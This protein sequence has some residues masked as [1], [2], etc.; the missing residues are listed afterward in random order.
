[1]TKQQIVNHALEMVLGITGDHSAPHAESLAVIMGEAVDEAVKETTG[2]ISK[3]VTDA[4]SCG[5]QQQ[6]LMVLK[7]FP[8]GYPFTVEPD[9]HEKILKA[10]M[11]IEP[12]LSATVLAQ[13]NHPDFCPRC[14]ALE[15]LLYQGKTK[16]P[17]RIMPGIFMA[18]DSHVKTLVRLSLSTTKAVPSWM[19]DL[20]VK[21][22]GQLSGSVLSWRNYKMD[23]GGLEVRATPDEIFT[24]AEG[25][26]MIVDYKTA[27]F[28]DTAASLF[29]RYQ[30]QLAIE[31]MIGQTIGVLHQPV[32]AGLLYME[33]VAGKPV[34]E[35]GSGI[36]FNPMLKTVTIDPDLPRQLIEKAKWLIFTVNNGEVP[37]GRVGCE[38]C[39]AIRAIAALE[40]K[41]E[42]VSSA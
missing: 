16:L 33:P 37:E 27:R 29:P 15:C 2:I 20:G 31:A 4:V 7:E 12:H 18:I 13:F 30:A 24:T 3:A 26:F 39:E 32:T 1:M 23:A 11:H 34:G 10:P 41:F 42:Q 35:N 36:D 22:T 19:P 17:F 38:Q 5:D 25:G 14:F 9:H 28:T 40:Q 8:H 21:V 6:L